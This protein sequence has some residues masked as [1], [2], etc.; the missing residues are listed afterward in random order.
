MI[1]FFKNN[2]RIKVKMILN[3]NMQMTSIKRGTVIQPSSFHSRVEV[4]LEGTNVDELYNNMVE[5]ILE[6]IAT[7]QMRGSQWVFSSFISLEIHSVRF[8]PLRGS[9]YIKLTQSLRSKKAIIN[10][11]NEDKMCFK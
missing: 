1:D 2:R 6:S 9:S 5:R 7:F 4:N 11:K 8:E 3:C 10:M